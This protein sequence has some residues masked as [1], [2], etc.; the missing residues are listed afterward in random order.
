MKTLFIT[1]IDTGIGKTYVGRILVKALI[2]AGYSC[3]PRKPVESGCEISDGELIP[4]DGMKYFQ[5]VD[6]KIPL[7]EI[8]PYRYEPPI[9][10][11]R[12]IRL[13]NDNVTVKDLVTSCTPTYKPDYLFVE[14][15]GGFYSPL[16]TDGLN[17]DLAQKLNA[18]VILVVKDRLGCINQTLLNIEAI[19]NRKLKL[20]AIVLNQT[21]EHEESSM[22]NLDDLRMRLS[23]PVIAIPNMVDTDQDMLD[24]QYNSIDELLKI[25][26][27]F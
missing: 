2:R 6:S 16:C 18:G 10:P 23:T 26:Y 19:Q 3:V 15:A 20:L 7:E 27:K 1:G 5:A 24:M 17:A 21:R 25:I 9:S 22:D 12:A 14:G 4:E 13:A 11:E 8:C